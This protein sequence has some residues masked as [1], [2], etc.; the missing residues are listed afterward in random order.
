MCIRDRF[1]TLDTLGSDDLLTDPQELVGLGNSF[2]S[3]ADSTG[4]I[5]SIDVPSFAGL[6]S[7]PGIAA[8]NAGPGPIVLTVSATAVPEPT[9]LSLLGLGLAV[10]SVRRRRK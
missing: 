4:L 5:T 2:W 10:A 1:F 3:L 6:S 8:A 7:E 9:S